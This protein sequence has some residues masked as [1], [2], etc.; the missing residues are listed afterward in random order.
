V[1]YVRVGAER[2]RAHSADMT[3]REESILKKGK[4]EER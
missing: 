2:V 4:F 3:Q 1:E